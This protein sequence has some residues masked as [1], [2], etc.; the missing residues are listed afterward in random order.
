LLYSV[1]CG[2]VIL[3]MIGLILAGFS[4]RIARH[5]GFIGEA[6]AGALFVFSGA[7]FPLTVLPEFLRYFSMG[8][9]V[10]WWIECLK[11]SFIGNAGSDALQ[12]LSFPAFST[13][14]VM[15]G[16][17]IATAAMLIVGYLV[18][19]ALVKSA[20]ERGLIDAIVN[21]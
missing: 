3:V 1:V 6:T 12:A 2:L 5:G 21:Y 16:L 19:R 17:G 8:L 13:P 18:F 9:P 7:V 10:S 15:L 11:R 20:R 14:A 4:M